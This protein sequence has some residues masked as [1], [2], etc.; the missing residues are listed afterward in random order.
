MITV[1]CGGVGA[2]RFL[3]GLCEVVDPTRVTGIVNVGDDSV[4]HGLHISPDLD[5]IT[6]TLAGS[7]NTET[8][9]GLRDES[10][11]AMKMLRFYGEANSI[12][13]ADPQVGEAAGWFSL[14]DRDLG[15]HLYRT[16]RLR[17]GATL[18]QVTREITSAWG[19]GLS[20]TPVTDDPLQ[21][22]LARPDGSE[23]AF[24]EYFVRER[25]N[26]AVSGIRFVGANDCRP[27]AGVLDAIRTAEPVCIA[28]S[29]PL[30][31]IAPI[32]AVQ[33][34]PDARIQ[35]REPAAP[36]FGRGAAPRASTNRARSASAAL[37]DGRRFG[38]C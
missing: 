37:V 14:G 25:H 18:S 16:S 7:M 29:N 23:L 11:N 1:L 33:A 27:A 2:A 34:V 35:A 6:Y 28:P 13:S 12:D 21:T 26:V 10:W 3:S 17:S 32:L 9:W 20:L 24:Q 4:I 15:T 36:S 38:G 22:R 5:T 8:G 30:I 19:L 31:S